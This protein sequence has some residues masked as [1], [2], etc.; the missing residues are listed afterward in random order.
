MYL[1]CGIAMMLIQGGI[2][3][4]KR[5]NREITLAFTVNHFLQM[6]LIQFQLILIS[7]LNQTKKGLLS[8]VPS[9]IL[10][11]WAY[12][13][14]QLYG[15]LLLYSYASSAVVPCLSALISGH[16]SSKEQGVVLGTF[17]S[18]GAFA[19]ALGPVAASFG[20]CIIQIQDC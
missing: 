2:V 16:S 7:I 13:W 1:F 15:S 17:R 19:R 3:R 20:N 9:F 10:I 12:S 14:Y 6:K 5:Q 18:L 11:G 8:V 4:R